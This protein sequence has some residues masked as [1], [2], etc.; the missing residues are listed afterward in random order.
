MKTLHTVPGD[1]AGGSLSLAVRS[2]G[3]KD[4]VLR[5]RDDLSCGPI[6][7]DEPEVRRAWW[8]Q[9][10]DFADTVDFSEFWQRVDSTDARL[11][12][13]FGRKSASEL[14]FFLAWADRLGDRPYD[15]VDVKL[16]MRR[17][18]GST[19]HYPG[20]VV[21]HVP[22]GELAALLG[23]ER[24]ISPETRADAARRWRALRAENAPF[25]V[26]TDHGLVSAPVDHF[27]GWI[28][29]EASP[30]WQTAGRVVGRAIAYHSDPY[31]QTGDVML[32]ARLVALVD[33]GKL[34]ADGDLSERPTRV[35]LPR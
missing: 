4:E 9:F 25:R 29:E 13:W 8:G 3:L 15:I 33:E 20:E 28:L 14:A 2:A 26:V 27:D 17:M 6:D 21:A 19:E 18:E 1:S 30:E 11:V 31:H 32:F 34:I 24:P 16:P 35:R 5:F 22:H 10:H 12:V 7:P 23:S